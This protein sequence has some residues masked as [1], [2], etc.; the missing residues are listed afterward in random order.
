LKRKSRDIVPGFSSLKTPVGQRSKKSKHCISKISNRVRRHTGTGK[1]LLLPTTTTNGV[2][3]VVPG[4][5]YLSPHPKSLSF[6][7]GQG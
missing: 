1:K 7:E 2:R 5:P 4:M 3:P 6:G